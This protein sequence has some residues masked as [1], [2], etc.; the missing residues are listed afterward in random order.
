MCLTGITPNVQ[1]LHNVYVIF[2]LFSKKYLFLAFI[3]TKFHTFRQKEGKS[4]QNDYRHPTGIIR[5]LSGSFSL[6][7]SGSLPLHRLQPAVLINSFTV[8]ILKP[9]DFCVMYLMI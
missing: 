9:C 2:V 8:L 6:P 4:I 1:N 5:Q 7:A 3:F